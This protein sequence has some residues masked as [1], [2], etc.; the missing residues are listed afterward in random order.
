MGE[1]RRAV[2]SLWLG[3]V[4]SI[5][6]AIGPRQQPWAKFSEHKEKMESQLDRKLTES[7]DMTKL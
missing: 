1:C 2:A 4:P 3:H 5:S 7:Q 6:L